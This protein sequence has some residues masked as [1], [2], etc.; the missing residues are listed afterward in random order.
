MRL[1]TSLSNNDQ[2]YA[3]TYPPPYPGTPQGQGNSSGSPYDPYAMYGQLP[4]N[5]PYSETPYGQAPTPTDQASYTSP[6]QL[7]RDRKSVV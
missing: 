6:E 1:A 2:D 3:M 5:T 7:L 4:A